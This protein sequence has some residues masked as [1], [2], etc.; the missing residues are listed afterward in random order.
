MGAAASVPI[1]SQTLPPQD[2]SPRKNLIPKLE[3]SILVPEK[4][5]TDV[6][7]LSKASIYDA[8]SKTFSS[9]FNMLEMEELEQGEKANLL[10]R[11]YDQIK[12]LTVKHTPND[13]KLSEYL[14]QFSP[15]KI[16]PKK[17]EASRFFARP[18]D[19]ETPRFGEAYDGERSAFIRQFGK[20]GVSG[21]TNALLSNPCI[22]GGGMAFSRNGNLVFSDSANHR[23]MV[24]RASDGGFVRSFGKYGT[25]PGELNNPAGVAVSQEG[26]III[27]D[28]GNHRIQIFTEEGE[29]VKCF[30]REGGYEGEF[31]SP[32][33][34]SVSKYNTLA[35][36]DT[37]NHRVQLLRFVDGRVQRVIGGYGKENDQLDTPMDVAFWTDGMLAVADYGNERVQVYFMIDGSYE[38]SIG[39]ESFGV[40]VREGVGPTSVSIDKYENLAVAAPRGPS[41]ESCILIYG[42]F[43][44]P[45]GQLMRGR[46]KG[47]KLLAIASDGSSVGPGT[48]AVADCVNHCVYIM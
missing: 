48:Y 22:G 1:A 28:T 8:I 16:D 42:R 34:V 44:K 24:V 39:L 15:R 29:Y 43:G 12:L 27:A 18:E 4:T 46:L 38:R 20:Q 3:E 19:K 31:R 37:G 11:I 10:D 36:A 35:V 33:G 2:Y 47:D 14:A 21:N 32:K 6:T 9:D 7:M 26:L 23:I 5:A 25:N 41:G 40:H 30:G 13:P 17:H 45:I